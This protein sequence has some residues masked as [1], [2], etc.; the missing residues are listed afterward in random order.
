MTTLAY[1]NGTVTQGTD[2]TLLEA[3]RTYFRAFIGD[4][5]GTGAVLGVWFY[6]DQ[7][8]A[9]REQTGGLVSMFESTSD[10][11]V[12]KKSGLPTGGRYEFVD[13]NFGIKTKVYGVSGS[14]K[15][16][17]WDGS[18]WTDITTGMI[19]DKPEHIQATSDNYLWAS[20]GTLIENSP[21]A[22][23][24]GTWTARTGSNLINTVG[25]VTGLAVVGGT[26]IVYDRS[27]IWLHSGIPLNGPA[28][29]GED[30]NFE[31]LTSETGAIEWSV[32]AI[33]DIYYL[34]NFGITSLNRTDQ[35][36]AGFD[37]NALSQFI[38]PMVVANVGNILASLVIRKFN[39]YILFLSDGRAIATDIKKNGKFEF[40]LFKYDTPI[41]CAV[42]GDDS[43]GTERLFAGGT[44]GYVYELETGTSFDG[45]AI[46][47]F[48]ALD[49]HHHGSPRNKKKF[50]RMSVDI[51]TPDALTL[52]VRTD[53]N[54]GEKSADEITEAVV[55]NTGLWDDDT[56]A[57]Y[58]I[59]A[60]PASQIDIP[61][62]GPDAV[63]M[64]PAFY[65]SSTTN[66]P[67]NIQSYTTD[68]SLRAKKR[69]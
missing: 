51:D 41:N 43:S 37:N 1:V 42:S 32:Q 50:R 19:P 29:A 3:T 22:D 36:V 60:N 27:K 16:F 7:V 5:P 54:Y 9:F 61:V 13:F 34:D 30:E 63:N 62:Y 26:L 24:K 64:G 44:D 45:A 38:R 65:N 17:E 11:W 10:G 57:T 48:A 14:H 39:E 23:P 49:Y 28:D 67:F 6:E 46:E 40:A 31:Q 66:R 18:T 47:S 52:Q 56:W 35:N 20:V 21:V 58:L 4:V 55:A 53:Y 2:P 12:E 25:D 33:G 69:N 68:L 8:M 59:P 15:A